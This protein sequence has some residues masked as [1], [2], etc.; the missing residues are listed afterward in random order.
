ME[1]LAFSPRDGTAPGALAGVRVLD[2]SRVLGGPYCTQILADHGAEVIKLE[3]P[4]GDENV[5]ASFQERDGLVLS[6][7]EPQQA[8]LRT[9]DGR[10]YVRT[11]LQEA[12]VLVENFRVGTME[13]WGL[14]PKTLAEEFPGLVY[15]RVTGFGECGPMGGLPAYDSAVQALVGLMSLNGPPDSGPC[16]V[17]FPVIDLVTG[18]HAALGV[19]F[20]LHERQTSGKGQYVEAALYDSGISLL[21]P[22]AENYFLSGKVPARVGNAHSNIYP[23]DVFQT[24]SVAIYLAVGKDMQFSRLAAFL[25]APKLREDP[26][27]ATNAH[28]SEHRDA[29]RQELEWLFLPLEGKSIAQG[30]MEAGVPC[31][32]VMGIDEVLAHPQAKAWG[33]SSISEMA[34]PA[35]G[36]RLSLTAPRRAT[37][38]LRLTSQTPQKGCARK[39]ADSSGLHDEARPRDPHN[40][41]NS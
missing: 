22:Y 27:F 25:G 16:R 21:H 36:P 1:T 18:L 7:C 5:G 40:F 35:W 17:G 8:L 39:R 41:S 23:Y 37:G 4:Q 2:L 15:C 29:L 32:P 26:R 6:R 33:M 3:P 9:E 11:L 24:N 31:S 20:A 19:M 12:D 38:S 13:R 14:G 34:T 28:R 30:L 10:L